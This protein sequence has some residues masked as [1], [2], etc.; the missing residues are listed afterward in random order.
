MSKKGKNTA[1]TILLEHRVVILNICY[2]PNDTSNDFYKSGFLEHIFHRSQTNFVKESH[3]ISKY[4]TSELP[5]MHLGPSKMADDLLTCLQI[6]LFFRFHTRYLGSKQP[7]GQNK[8]LN[9]KD[10]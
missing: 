7:L 1:K 10:E 4:L 9:L 6:T 2:L 8:L 3:V 5:V